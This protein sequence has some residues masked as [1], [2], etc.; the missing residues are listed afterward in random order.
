METLQSNKP[1][2]KETDTPVRDRV[3]E[4]QRGGREEAETMEGGALGRVHRL[5]GGVRAA[6]EGGVGD[7]GGETGTIPRI[8]IASKETN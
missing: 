2:R 3:A 4:T 8:K 6:G 5:K 1:I 7:K